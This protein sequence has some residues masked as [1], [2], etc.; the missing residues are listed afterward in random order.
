[1]SSY[2]VNANYTEPSCEELPPNGY[3][4]P[5][6][7][8]YEGPKDTRFS[9]HE[10]LLHGHD[11]TEPRCGDK[12]SVLCQDDF[13]EPRQSILLS[14][15]DSEIDLTNRSFC[16]CTSAQNI[17]K[18]VVYSWMKKVQDKRAQPGYSG[19]GTKRS[20]TAF[21]RQVLLELEKEFHFNRYLTRC[22]RSEIAHALC[23]S[24]RQVKIWFQNR[25]M[26]WKKDNKLPNTTT[27]SARPS[28]GKQ[29]IKTSS[30]YMQ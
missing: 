8:F 1:M 24:E 3:V 28:S 20:R 19:G 18:P 5:S 4:S 12:S 21:N 11:R 2:L 17:Q 26:K 30:Q 7:C 14:H 29:Q 27:C 16:C 10:E 6:S 22:R 25:R 15:S 9:E 13:T 23:L